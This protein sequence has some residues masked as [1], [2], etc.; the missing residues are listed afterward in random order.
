MQRK[1][2]SYAKY[3]YFFSIPFVLAFLIFNLYPLIYTTV[4]GFT[5][6]RGLMRTDINIL[7][8]PLDNF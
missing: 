8:N 1:T 3:G 7:E 2:I 6:L 4:I 5:D